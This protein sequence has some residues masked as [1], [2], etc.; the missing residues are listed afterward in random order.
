MYNYN[1]YYNNNFDLDY[2]VILLELCCNN[3]FHYNCILNFD[4][5]YNLDYY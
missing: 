5:D 3:L 1:H 4:L 2:N